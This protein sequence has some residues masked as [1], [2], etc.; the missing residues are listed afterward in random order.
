MKKRFLSIIAAMCVILT[1]CSNSSSDNSA[2]SISTEELSGE[3]SAVPSSE[4]SSDDNIYSVLTADIPLDAVVSSAGNDYQGMEITFGDFIKEYRYYLWQYGF[5]AD[6]DSSVTEEMKQARNDVID[7]IIKDRIIRSEFS[8]HGL[9]FSDDEKQEID[10]SVDSGME[11]IVSSI[12]QIISYAD[13]SLSDEELTEQAQLRFSQGLADCGL[14]R[15]DLYGWQEVNFMMQE[16]KDLLTD[17]M[18]ITDE[19]AD[20]QLTENIDTV[21]KAYEESPAEF[22]GQYYTNIWLPEGTRAIQAILVG[23]DYETYSEINS[24]RTAGQDEEADKLREEKL[25]DIQERYSTIMEKINAGEDFAQ[26]MTEYND[27]GG[28]GLFIVTPGTEIY[29]SDFYNCAMQLENI[30]DTDACLLDYGWYIVRY[31]Q[32][33]AVTD[34]DLSNTKESIKQSMLDSKKNEAYNTEYEKWAEKYSFTTDKEI[35]DL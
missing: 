31:Q 4:E 27:D 35:L 17:G 19:E 15:D 25:P 10:T 28:N 21:K 8:E 5:T 11:G 3:A 9:S 34:E 2:E 32:D 20:A 6:T 23:F 7:G 1:G 24:L 33:A 22:Y 13:S 26:L 18:E 12:K 29:G 30:G 16:L 14:T